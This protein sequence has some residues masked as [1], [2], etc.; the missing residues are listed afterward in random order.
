MTTVSRTTATARGARRA[1]WRAAVAVCAA[2]LLLT[3]ASDPRPDMDAWLDAWTGAQRVIPPESSIGPDPS[4]KSCQHVLG[5]LRSAQ[6]ALLP[7]PDP[8]IDDAVSA[9]LNRAE[10]HF[11]GCFDD[12]ASSTPV[13][14]AY[15]EL[16][17]LRAQVDS[18]IETG[19]TESA[20]TPEA[21]ATP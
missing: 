7:T 16:G 10:R 15:A 19:T 11:F 8:I 21:A 18:A 3:C 13:A 20:G 6:D 12:V 14:T 5:E 4:E 2:A 9:W 17:R 1:T